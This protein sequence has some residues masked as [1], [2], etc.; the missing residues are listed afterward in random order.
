MFTV[1]PLPDI[2]GTLKEIEYGMDVLKADGVG[3]Y[4]CYHDKWMGD[5]SSIRCSKSST[6]ARR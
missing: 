4:T 5:L 1:L 2:D 3:M 6:G